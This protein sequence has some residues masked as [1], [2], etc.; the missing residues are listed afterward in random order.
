MSMSID[1]FTGRNPSYAF[2]DI[3]TPDIAN[4][5]MQTL[6]GTKLSGR[7]VKIKPGVEKAGDRIEF[8][9]RVRN[10]QQGWGKRQEYGQGK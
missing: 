6:N 8:R 3:E 9:S 2:V 10:Y 1:P 5:A 7:P 4:R